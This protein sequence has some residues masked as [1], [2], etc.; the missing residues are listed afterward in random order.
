MAPVPEVNSDETGKCMVV[1]SN[2]AER[3]VR[4]RQFLQ[5]AATVSCGLS[6]PAFGQIIRLGQARCATNC[7]YSATL[8]TLIM[9]LSAS[10]R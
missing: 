4:R 8:P 9:P 1:T 6:L 3:K 2:S 10:A 7:R 5:T